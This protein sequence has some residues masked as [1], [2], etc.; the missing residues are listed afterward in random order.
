MKKFLSK[1]KINTIVE[2]GDIF[3]GLHIFQIP[4]YFDLV[5]PEENIISMPVRNH[6]QNTS[7]RKQMPST[8]TENTLARK[9]FRIFS[10]IVYLRT[11]SVRRKWRCFLL[12]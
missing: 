9:D 7:C 3:L 10:E 8:N 5:N 2:L 11:L 6:K 4:G 12:R 1:L